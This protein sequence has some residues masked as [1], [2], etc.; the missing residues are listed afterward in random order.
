MLLIDEIDKSDID[1]PNDLLH[2]FEEG[3]L[4]DPRAGSRL[5]D[6]QSEVEVWTEDRDVGRIPVTRGRIVCREFPFIVL[7]SNGER[8]FPR[9]SSA[10]ASDSGFPRSTV[11]SWRRSSPTRSRARSTLSSCWTTSRTTQTAAS[12]RPTSS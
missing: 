10:A 4:R 2:V 11:Y 3:W 6:D 8:A 7:T 5:P 1:L 9:P 12:W